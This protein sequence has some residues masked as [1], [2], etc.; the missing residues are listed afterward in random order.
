MPA[1]CVSSPRMTSG[2]S[3][4]RCASP[5]RMRISRGR[6]RDLGRTADRAGQNAVEPGGERHVGRLDPAL[7]RAG[8]A[9]DDD[10]QRRRARL[11]R[12][13]VVRGSPPKPSAPAV[14]MPSPLRLSAS[15]PAGR[16]EQPERGSST[17]PSRRR[18]RPARLTGSLHRR[19]A[20]APSACARR[21]TPGTGTCPTM[22]SGC[23]TSR[24]HCLATWA[25]SRSS[26]T[27]S[28]CCRSVMTQ[29][30]ATALTRMPSR[31]SLPARP[32]VRPTMP[33][34]AAV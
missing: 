18:R 5:G 24:M 20:S 16:V 34:L 9:A 4:L 29:P 32:L 15:D 28:S 30:G 23:M 26:V 31:P 2:A 33:A 17:C 8:H 3:A 12:R 19:S 10:R 25:A 11:R 7:A 21:R 13:D 27:Q 22:S 1:S 6:V 14:S